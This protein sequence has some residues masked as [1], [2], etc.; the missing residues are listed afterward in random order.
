MEVLHV[1]G[2][3]CNPGNSDGGGVLE[4]AVRRRMESDKIKCKKEGRRVLV[5]ADAFPLCRRLTDD[6]AVTV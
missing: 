1:K 3:D 5:Q 2:M 4:S 6:E